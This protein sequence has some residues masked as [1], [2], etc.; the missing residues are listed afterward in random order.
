MRLFHIVNREDWEGLGDGE[1]Y[2]P[3]SLRLDGFIHLSTEK[4]LLRTAARHFAEATDL[5]V[6]AIDSE[7]LK[8]PLRYEEAHGELY[9]HLHG[10]LEPGA[11]IAVVALPRLN[12]G[13]FEL[14]PEWKPWEQNFR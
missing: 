6:V 7:Q 9:P 5:L 13:S 12:D 2:Q 14:P 10:P 3:P 11:I 4:Q 8:G 1:H